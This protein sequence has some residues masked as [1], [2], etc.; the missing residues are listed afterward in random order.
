MGTKTT[1]MIWKL[2]GLKKDY[3]DYGKTYLLKHE[4]GFIVTI[5]KQCVRTKIMKQLYLDAWYMKSTPY[6]K[7][8]LQHNEC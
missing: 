5:R 1:E 7:K 4:W 8:V 2:M 6:I 3:V